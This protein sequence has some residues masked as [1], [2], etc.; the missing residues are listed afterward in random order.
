MEI[1]KEVKEIIEKLRSIQTSD[2][3]LDLINDLEYAMFM[4]T[5][6][7]R[8]VDKPNTKPAIHF[9]NDAVPV[10][11]PSSGEIKNGGVTIQDLILDLSQ[12]FRSDN[13]WEYSKKEK[14]C[15]EAIEQ[16]HSQFT[17]GRGE[18]SEDE[19]CNNPHLTG[20]TPN[21]EDA[22]RLELLA[23]WFDIRDN[24]RP[25][26]FNEVQQDLRR[27]A[28]NLRKGV[29]LEEGFAKWLQNNQFTMG[30]NVWTSTKIH[31][32]GGEYHT[33][34]LRELWLRSRIEGE[35]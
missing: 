3:G 20:I 26:A 24:Y 4:P 22:E 34:E 35:E 31:Y 8:A 12:I 13:G 2:E 21:K 1:L 18:V 16:Y 32:T 33:S 28:S 30:E 27:I 14:Y 10:L 5:E 15:K 23:K 25:A 7:L 29:E 9:N 17:G 11:P 19:F 6:Q